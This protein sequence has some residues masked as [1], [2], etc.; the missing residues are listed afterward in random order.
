MYSFQPSFFT[1]SLPRT[2]RPCR[3]MC[4]GFLL[5]LGPPRFQP[6]VHF[7][8]RIRSGGWILLSKS[9]V[10]LDNGLKG[11]G[12]SLGWVNL[13]CSS[14]WSSYFTGVCMMV[15]GYVV[16]TWRDSKWLPCEGLV[17]HLGEEGILVV[18]SWPQS[19]GNKLWW[20]GPSRF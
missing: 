10:T 19:E 11:L 3:L 8:Q 1:H 7:C 9:I 14:S 6:S 5:S 16:K 2:G 17:S 15:Q 12:L 20:D 4:A 13:L 18:A